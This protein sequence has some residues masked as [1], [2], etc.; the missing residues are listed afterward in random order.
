MNGNLTDALDIKGNLQTS[1]DIK[2]S[3]TTNTNISGKLLLG[4]DVNTTYSGTYEITPSTEEQTLNTN[5][6]ILI[7]NLHINE[8]PYQEVPNEYGDTVYIGSG[9]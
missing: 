1:V 8:I 5:N 7:G 6:K 3:L 4:S 2:G 9:D